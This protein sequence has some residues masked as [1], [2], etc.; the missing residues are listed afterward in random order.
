MSTTCPLHFSVDRTETIDE[1]FDDITRRE[2]VIGTSAI[3][4]LLMAGCGS[5]DDGAAGE[6]GDD[7][8]YPRTVVDD[9]G[10]SVDLTTR[11][12]RIVCTANLW[13]L[14]AL[15]S[16]GV[17]PVQFG[18]RDFSEFTGSTLGTWPWHEDAL[19]GVSNVERISLGESI[20]VEKIASA[21]PDLIVGDDL[22]AD[23]RS[24]LEAIAPVM[25]I[26]YFDWRK[27]L[28]MLGDALDRRETADELIADTEARMASALNGIDVSE[29]TIG[30]V[31]SYD[32]STF[33]GLGHD[34]IPAV[35]LFRRAGFT[36]IDALSEGATAEAPRP[37]FSVERAEILAEA[38]VILLFNYGSPDD[39]ITDT[40]LFQTLPAVQHQRVIVLEQGELAQGFSTLSPLN[41]DLC[42]AVVQE[43]ARLLN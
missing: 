35:D 26:A 11:P 36:T 33:Y 38:D 25:Q 34:S 39:R 41:L 32:S 43:A 28:R 30:L 23:V 37:E 14:D 20:N 18:V 3:A 4:A 5:D 24:Q 31:A 22:L 15:L 40:P 42:V 29:A 8:S 7:T 12:E 10:E 13:D 17:S 2:F 19:Q 1:V 21:R 27:N 9:A 16:L 6:T